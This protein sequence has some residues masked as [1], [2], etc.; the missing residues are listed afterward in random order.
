MPPIFIPYEGGPI[1]FSQQEV[2]QPDEDG[3]A[4]I[5]ANFHPE[6]LLNAYSSGLFPWYISEGCPFWYCPDPRM[7][8]FPADLK[9]SSSMRAV[10][11][12]K[13]FSFSS[14]TAF[15][16]VIQQCA[17]VV[18]KGDRTTW[19]DSHFIQAYN[20][21]HKHGYAHSF[22]CW[23][24]SHLVGGLYGVAIGEVFFGE[25]M[26]SLQPNASKA[27]FIQAV[28]FLSLNG[29]KMIDCQVYT[30]HLK[31][32]GAGTIK[33]QAFLKLLAQCVLPPALNGMPW[34]LLFKELVP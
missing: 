5:G 27:V 16:Q 33:R 9:I 21:L 6:T 30:D 17:T 2:I 15:N 34:T 10:F 22:E 32:L 4:A 25:S 12:K 18:R 29:F 23:H 13:K 28:R 11:N 31:S 20:V 26:F 19:I 1:D 8:L 14:D 24:E 7:V 3:L